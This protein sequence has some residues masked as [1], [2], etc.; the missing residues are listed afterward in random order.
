MT[1]QSNGTSDDVE[2]S[3]SSFVACKHNVSDVSVTATV[4]GGRTISQWHVEY[5]LFLTSD[6]EAS[7]HL[8]IAQQLAVNVEDT[9]TDLAQNFANSG[10]TM[11]AAGFT[12]TAPDEVQ[13]YPLCYNVDV[14]LKDPFEDGCDTY[15]R[16]PHFCGLYDDADFRSSDLC[17]ACGGGDDAA[18][19]WTAATEE[20]ILPPDPGCIDTDLT[21]KDSTGD[22]CSVYGM[23]PVHFCGE[24]DDDDFSSMAMCCACHPYAPPTPS[25]TGAAVGPTPVPTSSPTVMPTPAPVDVIDG[26]SLHGLSAVCFLVAGSVCALSGLVQ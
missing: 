15:Q 13:V 3:V 4:S 1:F 9:R 23:D 17:C 18:P 26:A 25:P 8:G 7:Y 16:N 22:N 20:P 5:E 14:G 19:D 24:F 10:L 11:V 12:I 2:S 21:E 6:S